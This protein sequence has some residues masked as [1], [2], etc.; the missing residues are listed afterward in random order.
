AEEPTSSGADSSR[1]LREV[2]NAVDAKVAA[3]QG[4]LNAVAAQTETL[5]ATMSAL[6]TKMDQLESSVLEAAKEMRTGKTAALA[7]APLSSNWTEADIKSFLAKS[8]LS[9][10]LLTYACALSK[11]RGKPVDPG[12]IARL[13]GVLSA[14]NYTGYLVTLA[15]VGLLKKKNNT[16]TPTEEITQMHSELSA[17]KI[18]DYILNWIATAKTLDEAGK[19]KWKSRT[20]AIE[21]SF[22]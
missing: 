3:L 18:K 17:P 14:N 5:H 13:T 4:V 2:S 16:E 8:P 10:N 9:L 15:A 1:E 12:E 22:D 21:A 19:E 6:P 20:L 11:L 7:T